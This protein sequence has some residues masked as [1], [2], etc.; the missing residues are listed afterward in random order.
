MLI[1]AERINA[2]R[3]SIREALE[4]KDTDFFVQEAQ[5]QSQAGAHYIDLNAGT[6]ATREVD[7]LKWLVEVVQD[8]VAIPVC[9]DSANDRALEEALKVYRK[10]E[11]MINSFTAEK[12]RIEVLLPIA[13]DSGA[14]VVGLAMGEGGI[15]QS[16]G[17]RMKLVDV[18]VEACDQYGIDLG[19]LWIDPLVVPI[20]TDQNQGRIFLETLVAIPA[21]Y[22]KVRTICGLSNISFGMPNRKLINRAFAGLCVGYGLGGAIID[23]LDRSLMSILYASEALMGQDEF[24]MNY[25]GAFRSGC[26]EK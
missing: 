6:E 2:T 23:P 10:K 19:K 22:P 3:K 20:G 25:L 18:L 12:E 14:D 11:V 7:D 1:V 15:P 24:C 4:K 21:K 8:V 26:L 9:L 13:R 17:D 16:V 5:R